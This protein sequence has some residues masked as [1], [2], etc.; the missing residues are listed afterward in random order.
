VRGFY[1]G[2]YSEVY[3]DALRSTKGC[4]EFPTNRAWDAIKRDVLQDRM[5]DASLNE[6]LIFRGA[7]TPRTLL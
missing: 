2:W 4:T 6:A 5:F 3:T 7:I 1:Q